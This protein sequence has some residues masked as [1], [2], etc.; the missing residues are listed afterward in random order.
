MSFM[1][2]KDFVI[3]FM[4][5]QKFEQLTLSEEKFFAPEILK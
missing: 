5:V 3:K 4:I 1:F 2:L